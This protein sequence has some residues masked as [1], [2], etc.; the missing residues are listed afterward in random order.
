MM[1]R[2]EKEGK[3]QKKQQLESQTCVKHVVKIKGHNSKTYESEYEILA[4]ICIFL[5][6][7]IVKKGRKF[8][9]R[10]HNFAQGTWN[11]RPA[12]Q[13]MHIL[14]LLMQHIFKVQ[15]DDVQAEKFL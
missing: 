13:W 14:Q 4:L 9:I 2:A 7:S 11:L 6:N 8:K 3:N 10:V 1:K 12:L 5:Q 15:I